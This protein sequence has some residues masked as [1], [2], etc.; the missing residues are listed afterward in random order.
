LKS[1]PL[2]FHTRK[3]ASGNPL[4]EASNAL[5]AQ[6]S[7]VTKFLIDQGVDK[8]KIHEIPGFVEDFHKGLSPEPKSEM[9][10]FVGRPT[11]EKGLAELLVVWPSN[12]QLDVV[13]ATDRDFP[14]F[15]Q[16]TNIH[17]LGIQERSEIRNNLKNYT[18]LI[19]PGLVWEGAYPLVVREAMEASVPVISLAGSNASDLV[20]KSNAGVVLQQLE[21]QQLLNAMSRANRGQKVLR[22]SARSFFEI[23]LQETSWISS[24]K[25][26]CGSLYVN[27]NS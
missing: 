6:S 11:P 24:M 15:S 5:I 4:L 21:P 12:K 22:V 16:Q 18:A 2:A 17:F 8:R 9:Y 14:E 1:I 7:R 27:V 23:Q 13:G 10:L 20:T 25:K 26:L 3:G 19:F